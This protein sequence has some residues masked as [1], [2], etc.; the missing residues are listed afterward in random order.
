MQHGSETNKIPIECTGGIGSEVRCVI[1]DC[2]TIS[3]LRMQVSQYT[4]VD[5]YQR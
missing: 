3:L 1:G 5:I 2:V 4:S